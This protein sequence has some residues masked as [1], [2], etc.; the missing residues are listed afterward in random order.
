MGAT[1]RTG[2]ISAIYKFKV[3]KSSNPQKSYGKTLNAITG[4]N[5]SVAAKNRTI[6]H[7]FSTIRDV[8]DV[9]CMSNLA[10]ISLNFRNFLQSKLVFVSFVNLQS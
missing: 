4:K 3:H 6:L 10:L 2:I 1:S 5:Q 7:T 8:I 9:P